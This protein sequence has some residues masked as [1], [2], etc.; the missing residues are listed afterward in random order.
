MDVVVID[1]EAQMIVKK[2]VNTST[3]RVETEPGERVVS[4]KGAGGSNGRI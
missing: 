4:L 3:A 2:R 1:G